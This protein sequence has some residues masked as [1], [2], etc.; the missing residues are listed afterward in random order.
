MKEI[1][2]AEENLIYNYH[3]ESKDVYQIQTING[4]IERLKNVT[5][6]DV[7]NE[8]I[9]RAYEYASFDDYAKFDVKASAVLATAIT[10]MTLINLDLS[11]DKWYVTILKISI[12]VITGIIAKKYY[13]EKKARVEDIEKYKL[14]LSIRNYLD[15]LYN[16]NLVEGVDILKNHRRVLIND[17]DLLSLDDVELIHKNIYDNYLDGDTQILK[18]RKNKKNT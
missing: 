16:Y 12:S 10:L 15:P 8:M 7:K 13:D 2:K 11:F 3:R 5:E 6:T 4:E 14:F 9:N 18:L 1:R 17:I